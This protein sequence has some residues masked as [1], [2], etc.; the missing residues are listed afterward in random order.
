MVYDETGQ[1][2][3]ML[4]SGSR[5]IG[6]NTAQF[7]D[8]KAVE[9][10]LGSGTVTKQKYSKA[11]NYLEIQS[12]AGQAYLQVLPNPCHLTLHSTPSQPTC[13]ADHFTGHWDKM[14]SATLGV[15]GH[16]YTSLHQWCCHLYHDYMAHES[17]MCSSSTRSSSGLARHVWMFESNCATASTMAYTAYQMS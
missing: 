5:W 7:Y 12:E 17:M 14:S 13:D 2:W 15:P 9:Y 6:N 16:A 10:M 3:V 4:H 11:I 1:I 8:G